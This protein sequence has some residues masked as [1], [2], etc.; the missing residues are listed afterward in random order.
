MALALTDWLWPMLS[1]SGSLRPGL[2]LCS[3]GLA[4]W[5]Q[6][7]CSVAVFADAYAQAEQAGSGSDRGSAVLLTVIP[8]V[9]IPSQQQ[10]EK[11]Y[12]CSNDRELMDNVSCPSQLQIHGDRIHEWLA[13]PPTRHHPASS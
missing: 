5:A 3:G 12:D 8:G 7:L 10:M 11:T 9:M 13:K 4:G 1:S 6:T 2:A